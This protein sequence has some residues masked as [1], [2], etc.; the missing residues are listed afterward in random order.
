MKKGCCFAGN[1]DELVV[2]GSD[3]GNLY[4]WE[5][6]CNIVGEQR[7]DEPLVV[8]RVGHDAEINNVRYSKQDCV[9]VSCDNH[10]VTKLWSPID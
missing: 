3:D 5:L 7:I 2:A 8:L 4:V 1:N 9:L 10:S 6:P